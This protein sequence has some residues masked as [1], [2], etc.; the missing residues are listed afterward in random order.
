MKVVNVGS[1][2]VSIQN[3][4]Q[5]WAGIELLRI[6]RSQFHLASPRLQLPITTA[7]KSDRW[8]YIER[9]KTLS[10]VERENQVRLRFLFKLVLA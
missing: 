1:L 8:G 2:W 9:L 4:L 5:M 3:S 7:R 6:V 10:F